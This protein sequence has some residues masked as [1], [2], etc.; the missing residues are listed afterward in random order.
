MRLYELQA[1]WLSTQPVCFGSDCFQI[2][3]N[4]LKTTKTALF[5]T[6]D[7]QSFVCLP[8]SCFII[9]PSAIYLICLTH[10]HVC[11]FKKG[12]VSLNWS[13]LHASSHLLIS[14]RHETEVNPLNADLGLVTG[15]VTVI[16]N[17]DNTDIHTEETDF[18]QVHCFSK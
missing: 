11:V 14:I 3:R 18:F 15:L 6:L 17:N 8:G 10:G 13:S 4:T 16:Y 9:L 5:L 7:M 2:L 12:H 1:R